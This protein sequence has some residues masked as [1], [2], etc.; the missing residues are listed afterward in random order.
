MKLVK[1]KGYLVRNPGVPFIIAFQALILA[2]AFLV[3]QEN[4]IVDV[5]AVS[6]F[7]FLVLGVVLQAVGSVRQ[8]ALGE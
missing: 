2:C 8:K 6:A 1:A 7:G 4:P 3:I 5:V